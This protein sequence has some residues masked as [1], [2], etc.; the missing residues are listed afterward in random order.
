MNCNLCLG[1][2][3]AKEINA[4]TDALTAIDFIK[5]VEIVVG[6]AVGRAL[7]A[8][9]SNNKVNATTGERALRNAGATGAGQVLPDR[10]DRAEVLLLVFQ[11]VGS[12][13]RNLRATD[14]LIQAKA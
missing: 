10:H 11:A 7:K 5:H 6:K 1:L 9:V 4:E 8:T 14:L 3:G 13:L 12:L 2:Q